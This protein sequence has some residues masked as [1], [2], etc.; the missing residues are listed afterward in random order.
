MTPASEL[1]Q[2]ASRFQSLPKRTFVETAIKRLI[3]ND[4]TRSSRVIDIY[5]SFVVCH[6]VDF[7]EQN[8]SIREA[9]PV[10]GDLS[11][12]HIMPQNNRGHGDPVPS[13]NGR[14]LEDTLVRFSKVSLVMH[15]PFA[16]SILRPRK[17]RDLI[18]TLSNLQ[19]SQV[20]DNR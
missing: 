16:K 7:C 9:L 6:V 15:S 10:L 20:S 12:R 3:N 19:T 14:L 2:I 8:D 11:G 4:N 1:C 5:D 18:C 17:R 13:S